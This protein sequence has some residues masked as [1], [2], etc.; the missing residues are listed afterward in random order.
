MAWQ[1][2]GGARERREG[3]RGTVNS[4]GVR[5]QYKKVTKKK[6]GK[7]WKLDLERKAAYI[8]QG[9]FLGGGNL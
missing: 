8:M 2:A 5:K 9:I 6:M 1:W 7:R 4:R 3:G